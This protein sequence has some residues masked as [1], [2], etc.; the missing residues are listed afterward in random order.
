M[1]SRR[2]FLSMGGA[3]TAGAL[4]P[5]AHA[6]DEGSPI[7]NPCGTLGRPLRDHEL[8]RIAFEGLDASQVWDCHAHLL[9]LGESGGGAWVS[10]KMQSI[11]QLRQYVQYR[12]YLNASCVAESRNVDRDFLARLLVLLDDFPVGCKAMVMAFDHTHDERGV[13]AP[14]QSA[15]HLPNRY[16]ADIAARHHARLAWT[17]SIHPYRRDVTEA[18]NEAAA[19]GA[20]AVKWLPPAMGIDPASPRCDSFYRAMVKHDLPLITHGGEEKAVQGAHKPAFGNVLRLR[21]PLEQGVRVVVAHCASLGSD[22][23]LDR[24]EKGPEVECFA[25]FERLMA[26][27]AYRGRLFGDISALPQTNRFAYLERILKH[28]DWE[29][30]LLN[31]SDYPLP[32]VF[33]LFSVDAIASRGWL[34]PDVAVHLKEVRHGNPLLFDFLLKRHLRIDGISFGRDVFE[35]ARVFRRT[36]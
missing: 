1:T 13:A 20:I 17:A 19:R 33:P 7:F 24:G 29:G 18:V 9:G 16:A 36:T 27:D 10:P 5:A 6:I 11:W 25:L 32:G 30:R 35:T 8:T 23:D 4:L 15:F 21:R 12:F 28:R 26:T 34:T 31:G 14:E 22:I 3:L 2:H